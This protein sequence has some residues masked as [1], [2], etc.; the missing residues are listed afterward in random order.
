MAQHGSEPDRPP[1]RASDGDRQ[2]VADLLRQH[3]T[4]GRL[5][6]EEYDQRVDAAYAARTVADL[7]PL[8]ADLPVPLDEVLPLHNPSAAVAHPSA[9]AV[10]RRRDESD[11]LVGVA[12]VVI[13]VL[14]VGTA[15]AA[16]SRGVFAFWP[17]LL[18]GI[19]LFGGRGGGHR[20]HR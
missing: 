10:A 3:T 4:D 5:T 19:F 12:L 9:A 8:L 18:I 15:L 16:A 2:R 6:I 14:L 13:A 7:R 20:H 1:V 17:L 11:R